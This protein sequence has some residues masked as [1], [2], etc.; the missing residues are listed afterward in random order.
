MINGWTSGGKRSIDRRTVGEQRHGGVRPA[1]V[2]NRSE[3]R[4]HAC[5]AARM[6]EVATQVRTKIP[7]AI[8]NRAEA[9]CRGVVADNRVIERNRSIRAAHGTAIAKP[10]C[11]PDAGNCHVFC[12]GIIDERHQAGGI[13]KSS[14]V[15]VA[16]MLW[17]TEQAGRVISADCLACI[18]G[19]V[20][21]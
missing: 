20:R 1:I 19:S 11:Y 7:P 21:G 12:K 14:P 10:I 8:D 13:K 17:R 5:D 2:I 9:V 4:I 18:K 15:S 16:A 6:A 3:E